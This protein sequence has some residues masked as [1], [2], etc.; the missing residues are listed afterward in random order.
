MAAGAEG[1]ARGYGTGANAL[2]DA[3]T[4][5]G[6]T[7]ANALTQARLNAS[8]LG[9]STFSANQRPTTP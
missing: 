3:Q 7:A 2:I 6:L 1:I 5:R 9:G 4:A 8:G